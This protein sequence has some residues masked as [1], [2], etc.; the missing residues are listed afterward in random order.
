MYV[1]VSFFAKA[2]DRDEAKAKRKSR[3]VIA[4]FDSNSDL[5]TFFSIR[6]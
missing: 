5:T 6:Q 3:R 4:H 2:N 1:P